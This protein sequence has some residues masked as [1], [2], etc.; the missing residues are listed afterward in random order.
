MEQH[1]RSYY[2]LV[3]SGD[4]EGLFK[5]FHPDI[6]YERGGT[7]PIQGMEEFRRFYLADRII[8]KGQHQLDS[9]LVDGEWVIVRGSMAGVLKNGESVLIHFADFHQFRDGKIWRRY[10]YFTDR[11]V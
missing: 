7:K 3:D 9:V 8:R 6:V 5:L 11:T 1:V 2:P 10:T 4:F